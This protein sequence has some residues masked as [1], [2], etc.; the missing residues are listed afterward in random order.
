MT[1]IIETRYRIHT[2]LF[3]KPLLVLQVKIKAGGHLENHGG[4]VETSPMFE[5]WVDADIH[6]LQLIIQE[7]KNETRLA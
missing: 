1:D 2:R 6:H 7:G 3:R 4:R 5:T